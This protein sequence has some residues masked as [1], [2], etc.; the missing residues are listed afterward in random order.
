MTSRRP[1]SLL[2]YIR[3]VIPA[4]VDDTDRDLLARFAA[5]RDQEAFAALVRRHGPMVFRVCRGVLSRHDAEDAFQAT[6]LILGRRARKL[7]PRESVGGWL[8]TV[9]YRTAQKARVAAAR[10][11]R[12]ERNVLAR[13]AVDPL[14][15]M[16]VREA[17]DL[18]DRE[19]ARLP[20]RFRAPLVMCYLEGLTREE[21]GRC[22]GWP[23]ALV[24][25]RLEQGRER[26]RA[27][28]T[29]RGLSLPAVLTAALVAEGTA[30]AAL[31]SGL[32]TAAVTAATASADVSAEVAQLA[33]GMVNAMAHRSTRLLVAIV[34][35]TGLA[36]AGASVLG[37]RAAA[38]PPATAPPA[39]AKT[40]TPQPPAAP[41][42]MRVVVLDPQ[43][44]PLPG[45]KVHSSIWTHEKDVKA[46][47]DYETDAAGAALVELPKS[48]YILRLWASKKPFV[49]MFSHWEQN[50]LVSGAAVP[51]AYTMRLETAVTAGG[52]V[53]D[54]QGRPIAG[55]KMQVSISGEKKPAHGDGR[56]FY[57]TWLAERD[58]APTTDA[59]GR[60]QITG[61]PAPSSVELSLI[62]THPDFRS[63]EIW[64]QSQK[65]SGVT[66]AMLRQGT[67]VVTLKRGVVVTGRV[68]DPDGK[69]IKDAI[70]IHGDDPYSSHEPCKFPTDADGRFRLPALPPRQ[71]TLTVVAP[72][73]AP[74]L[75]KLNLQSQATAQ[76]FRM[77]RGKPARLRVVDAAGQPVPN[78]S[79]LLEAW[80]GSESIRWDHNPNHP[81]V[82][83][84]KIPTQTGSDGVWEW[85]DAP[86]GPVK[87]SV[88]KSGFAHIECEVAGDGPERTV[89][90]KADPRITGRV[91]DAGTGRPI[92]SFT[93]IPI[94]VLRKDWLDAERGKAEAGTDGRLNYHATRTDIPLRLQIEAAGYRS[95]TGPQFRV[96]DQS[97]R[98]QDFRLR[99]S[100]PI[101]GTVVD[102]ARRPV[103]RA[104]VL[105]ATPTETAHFGGD[106]RGNHQVE[107]DPAGR[108][109]FPDPGEP[110]AVFVQSDAGFARAE[111]PPDTHDVGT[112]KLGQWAAV[113]GRFVDGGKPIGGAI[114]F[115]R[116]IHAWRFDRPHVQD[117]TQTV[118]DAEG[119][120]EFPR[121][122]PGPVQVNVFIGPWKDDGY[123]SGPNVP[124]DLRPGQR[125]EVDLGGGGATLTGQVKL[126][127]MVP[128]DL[129][130]TY[131]L[132]YL[133][134]RQPGIAPPPE[135]AAA[136]FN[137]RR[138]WS[139]AWT[140]SQEGLAY[141][142]TLRHW[143]VKL[144]PDGSFRVSGVPPGEYDLA[145]AVYAKP[146]GCLV[147]PLARQVA[148]VNVSAADAAR[149][150]LAVPEID[151][152]VVPV[153]TVGDKPALTF[154]RSDGAAG[155]LADL[156][157]K[158]VLV[159]F[160]ASWCGPCKQS[161]P[162]VRRLHGQYAGRGLTTLGLSVDEDAAAWQ[163]AVKRLDLPW[164]QGRCKAGDAGVGSVPVYWLL[165]SMGKIVAKGYDTDEISKALSVLLPG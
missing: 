22:L 119:R 97:N 108:F 91:T 118:T 105:L 61:V 141:L 32:V 154:H 165:D 28:L 144:A 109:E 96:G 47:R 82:P 35:G 2:R 30:T 78:A 48:F 107:T 145:V 21:A 128:A 7:R 161:L 84:T 149:G 164:S 103:A 116:P 95:E 152:T 42:A 117:D 80:R 41:Q 24:K 92:P 157:G 27:R 9:A 150:E 23:A 132:N 123:R 46:N 4:D 83:P 151:A 90:L 135:V 63:D 3:A 17:H 74:Q 38:D 162:A 58:D 37:L 34:L 19:L 160:W 5:D 62:V 56:T 106:H 98:V 115:L 137:V 104:K 26:L 64:Q 65:A 159:H 73:Y 153:P 129:D 36:G 1:E 147:E 146:S 8:H 53:V 101:T 18:L 60:W 43:G 29:A 88:W 12:H 133:V 20:D 50:E 86:E 111:L 49:A 114:I 102:S 134:R 148:G 69:P 140:M 25:S 14:A 67:A 163:E 44:K 124:L 142:S 143:F 110:S 89:V 139:D 71:T 87:V 156:R 68:T 131:S 13:P 155:T 81:K 130:C 40:D 112:L 113:R 15:E 127:G 99:P 70:V 31:P 57:N 121:V 77:G 93:V 10:R 54:E 52:R 39:N 158:Y 51:A 72:G 76:D 122:P 55:A 126:T 85:P 6:F 79:A 138:G 59:H 66:T 136:G 94:N 75:R 45:A 11:G 33:E 16:S 100:P 120:F 125:V